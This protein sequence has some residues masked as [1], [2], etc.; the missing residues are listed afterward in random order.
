MDYFNWNFIIAFIVLTIVISLGNTVQDVRVVSLSHPILLI[1]VSAQLLII[2]ILRSLGVKSPLTISSAPRG[3]VFRSGVYAIAEDIVAVDGKRGRAYRIQLQERYF[4]SSAIREVCCKL[5]LLW[6][7]SG[8]CV[9]G[10][11]VGVIFGV[12]EV[13]VGYAIGKLAQEPSY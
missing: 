10:A 8:V 2:G 3:E 1:E 13:N 5:D 11:I 9:G 4:A 7:V 12:S 6:G